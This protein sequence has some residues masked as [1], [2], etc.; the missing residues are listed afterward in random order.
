[1]EYEITYYDVHKQDYDIYYYKGERWV[2]TLKVQNADGTPKDLS[3]YTAHM[4]IRE[5]ESGK[6]I[7]EAECVILHQAGIITMTIDNGD[8]LNTKYGRYDV[9]LTDGLGVK[10]YLIKG[11]F[12]IIPNITRVT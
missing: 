7:K 5:D 9:Y 11:K 1:M 4:Q 3:G 12:I 6:L 8:N 10:T 2:H